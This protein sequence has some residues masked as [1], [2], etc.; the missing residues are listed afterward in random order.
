MAVVVG[1]VVG[2][3]VFDA[4]GRYKPRRRP[5]RAGAP[6]RLPPLRRAGPPRL[7]PAGPWGVVQRNQWPATPGPPGAAMPAEQ[8]SD[9]VHP[10][11]CEHKP[12]RQWCTVASGGAHVGLYREVRD[13]LRWVAC[14]LEQA[15]NSRPVI[16]FGSS[17][18]DWQL[19]VD[20]A[21]RL[22]E[23]HGTLAEYVRGSR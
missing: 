13:G 10:L 6:H 12:P 8:Q 19:P 9:V 1:P 3:R 17:K 22:G 11:W 7:R 20:A 14:W 15:P 18:H 21:L 2:V 16:R 5:P 4:F 23:W